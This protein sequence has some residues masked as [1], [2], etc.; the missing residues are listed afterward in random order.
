ML[1][2]NGKESMYGNGRPLDGQGSFNGGPRN[3]INDYDGTMWV[4]YKFTL[5][6]KIL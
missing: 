2:S 3:S 1:A 4:F 5:K 6:I